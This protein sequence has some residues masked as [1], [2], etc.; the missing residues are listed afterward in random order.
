MRNRY[1]KLGDSQPNQ[2]WWDIKN[3]IKDLQLKNVHSSSG[4]LYS[5]ESYYSVTYE[6]VDTFL[7]G[8]YI[9]GTGETDFQWMQWDSF[10]ELKDIPNGRAK[11]G[12]LVGL[13]IIRKIVE[14]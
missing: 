14:E 12:V 6:T 2:Q 1:A 11:A 8:R 5:G 9:I 13:E 10:T 7:C 3:A 4:K